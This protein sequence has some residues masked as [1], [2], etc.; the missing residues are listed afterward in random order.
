MKKLVLLAVVFGSFA[1]TSCSKEKDC[2]CTTTVPGLDPVTQ[3]Y[4]IEDGDCSDLETN[5]LISCEKK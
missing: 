3:V 2:E 4:T 1:L 5:S